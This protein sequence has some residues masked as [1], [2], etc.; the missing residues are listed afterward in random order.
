MNKLIIILI[1][2]FGCSTNKVQDG[3]KDSNVFYSDQLRI[4]LVEFKDECDSSGL[5]Y[6]EFDDVDMLSLS[7]LQKEGREYV[8]FRTAL[9]YTRSTMCGY[10]I[11]NSMPVVVYTNDTDIMKR[12]INTQKL[13]KG[14]PPKVHESMSDF[15]LG[16]VEDPRGRIYQVVNK[17]GLKLIGNR[18]LYDVEFDI[19]GYNVEL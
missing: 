17:N 15:A 13:K 10:F 7:F 2:F 14:D 1:L 9:S 4:A 6:K 11:L 8:A 16:S 18:Y 5:F 3:N 19:P 12:F